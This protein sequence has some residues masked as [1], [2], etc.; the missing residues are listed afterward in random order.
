MYSARGCLKIIWQDFFKKKFT[1]DFKEY[2][3]AC[4]YKISIYPLET[5]AI[6]TPP[7]SKGH[8]VKKIESIS[9]MFA[10]LF[11]EMYLGLS[12]E[13]RFLLFSILH[14]VSN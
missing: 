4:K 7:P 1:K 3:Y 8:D 5:L 6:Q 11:D 12:A 13:K 14:Y 10:Y 2:P 9:G